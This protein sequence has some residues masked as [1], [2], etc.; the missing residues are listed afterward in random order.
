[1][2]KALEHKVTKLRE[3]IRKLDGALV[4]F[5]GGVDSAFLMRIVRD[6][7]GDKAV[8]VTALPKG[9]PRAD[10]AMARRVAKIL[11]V[12]HLVV[13][14]QKA[15][16]ETAGICNGARAHAV[17]GCNLYSQLKS[18]AMRMKPSVPASAARSWRA[19]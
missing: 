13:R 1:M 2:E 3:R 7:L 14:Q 18:V 15:D 10:L 9:Y 4:A 11:G 8:A 17:H 16:H 12:K 19:I 6:E 5:S